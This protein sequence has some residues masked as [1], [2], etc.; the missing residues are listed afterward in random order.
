MDNLDPCINS[1]KLLHTVLVTTAVY[2]VPWFKVLPMSSLTL[3]G[4]SE[5]FKVLEAKYQKTHM[6]YPEVTKISKGESQKTNNSTIL[7]E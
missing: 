5:I 7:P 2:E 1:S 4:W 6:L 3:E